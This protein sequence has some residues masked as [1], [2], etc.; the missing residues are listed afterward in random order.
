MKNTRLTVV[1]GLIAS[2]FSTV[3]Y[4]ETTDLEN[5]YQLALQNDPLLSQAKVGASMAE[6]AVNVTRASLLPQL[7]SYFAYQYLQDHRGV[8]AGFGGTGNAVALGVKG[9]QLLYSP[10]VKLAVDIAN[11]DVTH[12]DLLI[13]KASDALVLRSAKAY[14]DVLRASETVKVAEANLAAID[15]FRVQTETRVRLGMTAALDLQEAQAR[16]DLASAG[17]INAK[18]L[19][20]QRLDALTTLTGQT[21][22]NVEPL[23]ISRFSPALPS[24]IYGDT[25]QHA[26]LN[27]NHDLRMT[28]QAIEKARLQIKQ[29]SAGRMPSVV[30]TAGINQELLMDIKNIGGNSALGAKLDNLTE[31]EVGVAAQ[32]PLY[33]GGRTTALVR[34]AQHGL[35]MTQLVN[36][37]SMRQVAE[38]V[39]TTERFVEASLLSLKAHEQSLASSEAALTAVEKG[40]EV[41]ARTMAEVLAA[42][43]LVYAAQN[44][45]NNARFD[46]IE[47][48]LTLKFLAGELSDNDITAL[49]AGLL[50]TSSSTSK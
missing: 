4:A 9:S 49:N 21:F 12:A 26:A 33:S 13:E 48:A 16:F 39:N 10:A 22:T 18:A 14:F 24:P 44:N 42:T 27:N 41:G 37:Q 2:T 43:G 17:I 40:Y 35:E 11:Q 5:L 46:F 45:V 47:R 6:E 19:L 8:E 28:A 25:W 20:A 29:A 30:F 36:D 38:Q 34:L 1:A 50:R 3:V 23:D 15:E 32:L 31:V 7:N